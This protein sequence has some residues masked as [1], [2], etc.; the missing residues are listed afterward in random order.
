MRGITLIATAALS[1]LLLVVSAATGAEGEQQV[2]TAPVVDLAPLMER[3]IA[4]NRAREA[5]LETLSGTLASDHRLSDRMRQIR[6]I[7]A[8]VQS[9]QP[10]TSTTPLVPARTICAGTFVVASDRL[11]LDGVVVNSGGRNP[12]GF[13]PTQDPRTTPVATDPGGAEPR[14]AV[15]KYLM[16]WTAIIRDG[17]REISYNQAMRIQRV[18][19][20]Q[21]HGAASAQP[22]LAEFLFCRESADAFPDEL[23]KAWAQRGPGGPAVRTWTHVGREALGAVACDAV[24]DRFVWTRPVG[25]A[26]V[27]TLGGVSRYWLAPLHGYAPVRVEHLQWV[28]GSGG[29]RRHLSGYCWS[30]GAYKEVQPGLWLPTSVRVD[31][32]RSWHDA[33]EWLEIHTV[34][35]EG[36][37]ANEPVTSQHFAL[38]GPP[39]GT[40]LVEDVELTPADGKAAREA[41]WAHAV[42]WATTPEVPTPDPGFLQRM[43]E[44]FARGVPEAPRPPAGR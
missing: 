24:E 3:A 9:G 41:A 5:A 26:P 43:R 27:Y 34:R 28:G 29:P 17:K 11:R 40:R 13:V 37:T 32:A 42:R 10:A 18:T 21:V 2:P 19:R 31:K 33:V 4:A 8:G 22:P 12:W 30:A 20:Q 6:G 38:M 36:L 25:D 35:F 23:G 15:L 7:V 14:D 16:P 39:A 1:S 44:E